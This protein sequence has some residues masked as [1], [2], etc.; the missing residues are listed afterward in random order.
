MVI[1]WVDTGI[2]IEYRILWITMCYEWLDWIELRIQLNEFEMFI[3]VCN[4]KQ[5][6]KLLYK[7]VQKQCQENHIQAEKLIKGAHNFVI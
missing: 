7:K 5:K 3:W 1:I 4:Y 6:L 2:V